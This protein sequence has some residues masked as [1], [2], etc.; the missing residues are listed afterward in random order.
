MWAGHGWIE[1]ISAHFLFINF[2]DKL[3]ISE[4]DI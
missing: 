1:L 4:M 3:I 2:F